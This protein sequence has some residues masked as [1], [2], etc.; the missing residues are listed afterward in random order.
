MKRLCGFF[1]VEENVVWPD[2][3]RLCIGCELPLWTTD[4]NTHEC[5]RCEEWFSSDEYKRIHA[6][7][8][9]THPELLKEM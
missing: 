5:H 8:K 9:A 6:R 1:N 3:G 4:P 2:T 7:Y